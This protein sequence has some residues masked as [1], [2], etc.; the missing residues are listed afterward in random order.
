MNVLKKYLYGYIYYIYM[1]KCVCVCSVYA[2][3]NKVI[4]KTRHI[5]TQYIYDKILS[6]YI[7]KIWILFFSC[8]SLILIYIIF[9]PLRWH[10]SNNE[11]KVNQKHSLSH[12]SNARTNKLIELE[13]MNHPYNALLVSS[14][15]SLFYIKSRNFV[16]CTLNAWS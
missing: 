16:N 9:S 15:L 3:Q 12:S 4:M 2:A 6:I 13:S 14:S 7:Y 1:C 10:L 11:K 5:I 8:P